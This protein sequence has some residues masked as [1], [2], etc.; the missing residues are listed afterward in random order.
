M[1]VSLPLFRSSSSHDTVSSVPVYT[2]N[3]GSV[4][5]LIQVGSRPVHFGVSVEI[6]V[7]T[8][9]RLNYVLCS[10]NIFKFSGFLLT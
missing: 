4:L 2:G 6:L 1:T 9:L 7:K 8:K 10:L 5:S 3:A